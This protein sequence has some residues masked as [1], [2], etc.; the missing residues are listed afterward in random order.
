M[1]V[2][3]SVGACFVCG[4][5]NLHCEKLHK[6]RFLQRI[7]SQD[8][9][10]ELN[11]CYGCFLEEIL[12]PDSGSVE[13]SQDFV[14]VLEALHQRKIADCLHFVEE[15]TKAPEQKDQ[16]CPTCNRR[17]AL[18]RMVHKVKLASEMS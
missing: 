8:H 7:L 3:Q 14:T 17:L 10:I 18:L 11:I 9:L 13:H 4:A 12:A 15:I 16:V 1:L 2:E 5:A 6:Y